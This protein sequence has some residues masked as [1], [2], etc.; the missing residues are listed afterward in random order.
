[1]SNSRMRCECAFLVADKAMK[2]VFETFFNRNGAFARLGTREFTYDLIQTPGETDPDLYQRPDEVL[3]DQLVTPETHPRVVV[4]L[5]QQFHTGFPAKHIRDTAR[6]RLKTAGWERAQ[7]HVVVIE[8]ELESWM[9]HD[10]DG[11][12]QVV[13][14]AFRYDRAHRGGLPLREKLAQ[15]N[16]WPANQAKPKDPKAAFDWARAG[17]RKASRRDIFCEIVERVGISHCQDGAFQELRA[18]LA[19]W[20]PPAWMAHL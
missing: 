3:A 11:P 19:A 1:M 4:T 10:A 12:M 8:P 14:A 17:Y 6:E 2:A 15:Q 16:F 9:W 7:I 13:E 5:D 20:F 18:V